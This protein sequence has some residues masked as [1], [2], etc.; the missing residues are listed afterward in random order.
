LIDVIKGHRGV[1]RV[2]PICRA[3]PVVPSTIYAHLSVE[4]DPDKAS[5]LSELDIELCPEIMHLAVL[6]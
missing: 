2:E 1:C 3:L 6:M 4:H 5:D